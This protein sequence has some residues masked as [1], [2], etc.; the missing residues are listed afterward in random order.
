MRDQN[1]ET[2]ISSKHDWHFIR[3]YLW[4]KA[5]R[6]AKAKWESIL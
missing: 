5:P 2:D 6:K 3:T 4:K 1:N